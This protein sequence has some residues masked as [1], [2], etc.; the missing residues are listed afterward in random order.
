[1]KITL[2]LFVFAVL[3]AVSYVIAPHNHRVKR[4]VQIITIIPNCRQWLCLIRSVGVAVVGRI[5]VPQQSAPAPA[6]ISR[7]VATATATELLA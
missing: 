3:L 1:M 6:T 7:Q 4:V 2:I 5:V